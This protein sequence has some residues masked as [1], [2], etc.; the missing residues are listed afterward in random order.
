MP[1]EVRHL[2]PDCVVLGPQQLEIINSASNRI[3][4]VGDVG[5]GKSLILLALLYKYT[6]KCLSLLDNPGYRNVLFIIPENRVEFRKYV[7]WFIT[8]YC[9]LEFVFFPQD[10]DSIDE[11][12]IY[13]NNIQLVLVDE[14]FLLGISNLSLWL[15]LVENLDVK[16]CCT[17]S[18]SFLNSFDFSLNTGTFLHLNNF[19]VFGLHQVYR[20]P[21]NI[22]MLYSKLRR[23]GHAGRSLTSS[24]LA[25]NTPLRY[26][27][28]VMQEVSI[29]VFSS[30]K[31]LSCALPRK[32]FENER[33]L[34]VIYKLPEL[35]QLKPA[36]QNYECV[37]SLENC[38]EFSGVQYHCV[39]IIV[40]EPVDLDAAY[41]VNNLGRKLYHAISRATDK[42][43]IIC[44][45]KQYDYFSE[46]LRI[47]K[48]DILVLEKL[49]KKQSVDPEDFQ[50][51]QK[52]DDKM[53][54]LA[55]LLQTKNIK[56]YKE[57]QSRKNDGSVCYGCDFFNELMLMPTDSDGM[58]KIMSKIL[59]FLKE[60]GDARAMG[61]FFYSVCAQRRSVE[62]DW[63]ME[64]GP[65]VKSLSLFDFIPNVN[66]WTSLLG[67]IIFS[68]QFPDTDAHRAC[69]LRARQLLPIM[70][71]EFCQ[72]VTTR[73]EGQYTKCRV[74]T[75]FEILSLSKCFKINEVLSEKHAE[76]EYCFEKYREMRENCKK[77]F[78]G[79]EEFLGRLALR[80]EERDIPLILQDGDWFKLIELVISMKMN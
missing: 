47:D 1:E 21:V 24:I 3:L 28:T 26:G 29:E 16:I 14:F 23:H 44:H 36:L 52:F 11:K 37:T 55:L 9:N 17:W 46:L 30:I 43:V 65:L 25:F 27:V 48:V 15:S 45:E 31:E 78:P 42:L 34:A 13:R 8:E 59:A 74:Q 7:E 32:R 49:R 69:E 70:M 2:F 61:L 60:A 53:E 76:C 62:F 79:E 19:D 33:V 6:A 58:K 20:C 56:H 40:G 77:P 50:L 12:F 71:E 67:F 57:M 18:I 80:A 51:L 72:L 66:D 10:L 54:A 64:L 35:Q 4:I 75:A 73:K 38:G 41:D 39:V 22:A 68:F 5:T 63:V